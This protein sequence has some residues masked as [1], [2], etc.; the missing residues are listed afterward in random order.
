MSQA[1]L[2]FNTMMIVIPGTFKLRLE[3]R[4]RRREHNRR[5]KRSHARKLDGVALL[6]TEL[7]RRVSKSFNHAI[8]W[9]RKLF[10]NLRNFWTKECKTGINDTKFMYFLAIWNVFFFL[11]YMF[12]CHFYLMFL[13]QI[14]NQSIL[15][16]QRNLLLESLLLRGNSNRF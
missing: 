13:H 10:D 8:I 9:L 1:S 12:L 2:H 5:S 6:K 4:N 15:I 7:P 3:T 14:F 16:A 11:V